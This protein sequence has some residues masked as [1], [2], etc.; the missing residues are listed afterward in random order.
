MKNVTIT[1]DEAVLRWARIRAAEL[2]TSVSRL[3]SVML[4]REMK[5]QAQV[6]KDI[7]DFFARTP[8]HPI[9]DGTPYPKREELYDRPVLRGYERVD[10]REGQPGFAEDATG[11][12]LDRSAVAKKSRRR[13][14]P[15]PR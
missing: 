3:V 10:L 15:N 5:S 8:K 13:K 4:E 14:P 9:S 12:P 2:D 6:E 11:S 1:L 7:A